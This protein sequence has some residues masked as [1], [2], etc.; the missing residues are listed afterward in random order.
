M[1]QNPLL[2]CIYPEVSRVHHEHRPHETAYSSSDQLQHDRYAPMAL[3]GHIDFDPSAPEVPSDDTSWMIQPADFRPLILHEYE[4][5]V[6][7]RI[8]TSTAIGGGPARPPRNA[9]PGR[10]PARGLRQRSSPGRLQGGAPD[11]PG[12]PSR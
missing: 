1:A 8:R 2:S 11:G 5:D 10:P 9:A 3:A 7:N 6:A 4:R 12:T